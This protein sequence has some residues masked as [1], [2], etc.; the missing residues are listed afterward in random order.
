M[1]DFEQLCND[2]RENKRLIEELTTMNDELKTQIVGLMDGQETVARGSAKASYKAVS[3]ERL[4]TKRIKVELPDVY[5]RYC[6]SSTYKR[7]T[8]N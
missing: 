3:S 6:V 8:V 4:D 7:F 2:Y 1:Q 5:D